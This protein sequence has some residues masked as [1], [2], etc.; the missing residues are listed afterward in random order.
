MR[1][2]ILVTAALAA[3]IASPSSA[4]SPFDGVWLFDAA[5][6]YPGVTMMEVTSAGGRLA[7]EVTT[8]WYGP[9]EMQNARIDDGRLQFEL[10]N[11]ND[12]DHPTRSWTGALQQDRTMRLVGDIWYAH[13]EQSGR[14]GS[15]ADSEARR[16]RLAALAPLGNIKPDGLAATPPMG[17]SSWNKFQDKIDDRTIREIADA[18]V[19]TGLRDAGYVYVNIDDG[20]QG[21]RSAT[22]EIRPNERF[23]DMKALADYLHARGLKL[24]IYTSPGPKSCAGYEGSYGHVQQDARTFARWGVDYVKYDLCSGEWFYDDAEKVKRAYY[25]FG[26]ALKETGR[27][28]LY[29]LCEYGRFDVGSWARSVGG[30]LWRVSGDITDDYPTM[31]RIGFEKHGNAA[32]SGRGGW[33]DLDMLEVG[34]GGMS[35]DEYRTHMS[36]WA[37]SASPLVMG[38]DVRKSDAATLRLLTNRE[39]IAVDQDPRGIQGRAVRTIEAGEIWAKP[40]ADGTVAL[41]LFNL[42]NAPANM[43]V[44]PADAG[45]SALTSVRDLWNA[46]ELSPNAV[47]F[48]VPPHGAILLRVRGR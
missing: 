1:L 23:P 15:A 32:D 43:D 19:A 30:H 6:D 42:S 9:M 11:L 45:F 4:Q 35:E 36:L 17:W 7:G 46:V 24:G 40:L 41:G 31:A 5:P 47:S 16:F 10:R 28:I 3:L 29:S 34:N 13:V 22:G 8:K 37:M 48:T 33:N 21:T 25:E 18:M 27:P 26:A 44:Q 12:K 38:H 39:V 2:F 14:P 20:W